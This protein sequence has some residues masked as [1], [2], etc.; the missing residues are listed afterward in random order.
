MDCLLDLPTVLELESLGDDDDKAFFMGLLFIR[1]VEHRRVR[2]E[3]GLENK[4]HLFVIEEA[5]RL[6]TNV[7]K[8]TD[9]EQA[10][11]RGKAVETF[12]NLL[13]EIRAYDEGVIIADQVPSRLAP[14]VIKNTNLKIVHRI[15]S[16]D[17][18]EELGKAMSMNQ[19]QVAALSSLKNF[20]AA[21]FSGEVDDAPLLVDIDFV[22]ARLP[23]RGP[24]DERVREMMAPCESWR[25]LR[26]AACAEHCAQGG[27]PIVSTVSLADIECNVAKRS[28]ADPACNEALSRL[29]L[30]AIENEAALGQLSENLRSVV[31][32]S[33]PEG[34]HFNRFYNCYLV[35]AGGWLSDYWGGQRR[36]SQAEIRRFGSAL[37]GMLRSLPPVNVGD[38]REKTLEFQAVARELH[39]RVSAPYQDCDAICRQGEP[40]ERLCLYRHPAADMLR[41]F[42][43][44]VQLANLRFG[45][46]VSEDE[47]VDSVEGMARAAAWR[48]VAYTQEVGEKEFFEVREAFVRAELCLAQQAIVGDAHLHPVLARRLVQKVKTKAVAVVHAMGDSTTRE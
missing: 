13:S 15:V 21:V 25:F 23:I 45:G 35:H 41:A 40:D 31:R 46:Y 7:P 12:T 22:K 6:L 39:R 10:D 28:L 8:N 33:M 16:G 47:D 27:G 19:R 29:V 14:D 42:P 44:A 1:L 9:D 17:D 38:C 37:R 24:S 26:T 34:V 32:S 4:Q 5:H 48:L 3:A 11:P 2:H 36:W 18:R 20:R 30:S 43:F